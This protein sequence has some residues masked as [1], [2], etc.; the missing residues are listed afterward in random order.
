VPA[1]V[2]LDQE[3]H[4]AHPLAARPMATRSTGPDG[5][6]SGVTEDAAD[7]ARGHRDVLAFGQ[8]IRQVGSVHPGIRREGELDQP[9]TDRRREP[10]DRRSAGVAMD[11]ARD[12]VRRPIPRQQAAHRADRQLQSVGGLRGADLTRQ[13]VVEDVQPPLCSS[14]QGDR[15]PLH[16]EEGDKVAVRLQM[17]KSLAVHTHPSLD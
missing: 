12:P 17:T 7:R 6:Q 16:V 1:A 9:I 14:V 5:W 3:T 8:Q 11:Q 10:I 13:D 2:D 15:L 4:L